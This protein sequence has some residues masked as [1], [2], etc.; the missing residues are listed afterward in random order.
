MTF[1]LR[2]RVRTSSVRRNVGTKVRTK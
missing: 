1:F 2:K